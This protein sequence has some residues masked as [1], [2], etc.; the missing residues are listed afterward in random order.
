MLLGKAENRLAGNLHIKAP[1]GTPMA[2]AM[3]SMMHTLGMNDLTTFGDSTGAL[4]LNS[5][6]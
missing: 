6:A 4:N 5:H 2:N 3:L 1:D